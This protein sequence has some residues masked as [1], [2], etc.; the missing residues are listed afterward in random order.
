MEHGE[1]AIRLVRIRDAK[2][3]DSD[4]VIPLD[5][6]GIS[7]ACGRTTDLPIIIW[8][9][10][11]REGRRSIKENAGN[12]NRRECFASTIFHDKGLAGVGIEICAGYVRGAMG[13]STIFIRK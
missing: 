10:A 6:T 7:A 11:Q 9:A 1:A 5:H 4:Q 8:A 13:A 2:L 12:E 3:N